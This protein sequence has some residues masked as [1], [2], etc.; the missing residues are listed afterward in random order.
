[1]ADAS[2]A[3]VISD[4]ANH[5]ATLYLS[6]SELPAGI[7]SQ[8]ELPP[9]PPDNLFD[10]RFSTGYA[11]EVLPRDHTGLRLLIQGVTY[12]V[13]IGTTPI[14]AGASS[15]IIQT[16]NNFGVRRE[17][18]LM[19][20]H[21]DEELRKLTVVRTTRQEPVRFSLLPAYPNPFNPA[22]HLAFS[23]ASA[24][25]VEFGIYNLLGQRV[26]VLAADQLV[27]GN[28]VCHWDGK[29]ESGSDVSSGFYVARITAYEDGHLVYQSATRLLLVR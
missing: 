16:E 17:G 10:A 6:D 11:A 20:L 29:D 9:L 1:M 21:C 15:L 13:Q 14:S 2:F 3:I 22:T 23:L 27:A 26:R 24:A 5:H 4:A 28:H 8:H 25:R 18:Q 7:R 12:P 19:T